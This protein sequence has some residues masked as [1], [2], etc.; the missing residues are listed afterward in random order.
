MI[1]LRVK[2]TEDLLELLGG[3]VM[4]SN[5]LDNVQNQANVRCMEL[6]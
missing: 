6:L 5:A 3:D 4:L 1:A 2:Q